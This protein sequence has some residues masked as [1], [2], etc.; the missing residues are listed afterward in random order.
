MTPPLIVWVQFNDEP[1]R[2]VVPPSVIVESP[3]EVMRIIERAVGLGAVVTV[4][5][6]TDEEGAHDPDLDDYP[7]ERHVV[8]R[9]RPTREATS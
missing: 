8:R 2:E 3:G 7:A 6:A 5:V 4:D 1:W 9:T